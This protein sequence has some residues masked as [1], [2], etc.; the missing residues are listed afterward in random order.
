LRRIKTRKTYEDSKAFNKEKYLSQN[1]KHSYIKTKDKANEDHNSDHDTPYAYATDS[2]SK[3]V[4]DTADSTFYKTERF[5]RQSLKK[6]P[7]TLKNARFG[8]VNIKRKIHS[9]A[10]SIK[11]KTRATIKTAKKTKDTTKTAA[12]TIKTTKHVAQ[13]S[14]KAA[15]T[16]I[17]TSQR[18]AQA[19]KAVAK[20]SARAAKITAKAVVASIKATIAAVKGLITLIAA[21]GWVAV[22]IILIICMVGFILSSGFGIFYSNE[23]ANGPNSMTMSTVMEQINNDF[24]SGIERIKQENPHD[25]VVGITSPQN[26]KEVLAVY[27]VKHSLNPN[28]PSD[29]ATINNEK[30]E[31]IKNIFWEMNVI[32]FTLETVEIDDALDEQDT[33]LHSNSKTILHIV[34]KNKNCSEMAAQYAFNSEQRIQLDELLKPEYSDMWDALLNP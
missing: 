16:I 34:V 21:G 9:T 17:K 20:T 24:V 23:K 1:V 4:K 27:S 22:V 15:Q 6:A 5:G 30:L 26:W 12:N 33:S 25:E 8:A 3:K 19:A 10:K 29:V 31:A 32:S 14:A 13:A 2:I 11:T 18:A 7:D 28:N